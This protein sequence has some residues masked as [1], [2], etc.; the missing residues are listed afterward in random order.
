MKKHDEKKQGTV[1]SVSSK[2]HVK[3][4]KAKPKEM[5]NTAENAWRNKTETHSKTKQNKSATAETTWEW[6]KTKIEDSR[7]STERLEHHQPV[8]NQ[9]K[10]GGPTIKGIQR[11][12]FGGGGK[13]GS[14][15]SFLPWILLGIYLV[16]M[17]SYS[18]E[19]IDGW[20]H[21]MHAMELG[22]EVA[23]SLLISH[24]EVEV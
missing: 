18:K 1:G 9:Y 10:G 3:E 21:L 4:R 17:V 20:D 8:P 12:W 7:T 6:K 22:S 13:K 15:F 11:V 19:I 5:T 16:G 24:L 23:Q 14:I 2:N